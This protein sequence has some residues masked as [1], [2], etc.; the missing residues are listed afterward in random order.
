MPQND[1]HRT[2]IVPIEFEANEQ[3]LDLPLLDRVT[4]VLLSSG[5]ASLTLNG[6]SV[7]LE[8]PCMLLLSQNDQLKLEDSTRMAAKSFSFRPTFVN[9]SLT[10]ERLMADDFFELED[11]HDRNMM[12]L[13]LKRDAYYDGT[14]DLPPQTYLRIF[15]W[16]AIMG[17]ETYAQSD[18]YWTCRIRRYL[19][20][21]LYLLDDI[22]MNRKVPNTIKR[23]KSQVDILLEYIHTNYANEISLEL[24]TKVANLN[25]TSL[26]R[27]F[28]E[29]TGH[30]AMEYLLL[31]RLKIAC[32]AL[33]HTNLKLA[34]IA[35]AIGFRYDTYFIRQFSAR[36]GVTP[37]EYRQNARD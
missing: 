27:K 23:E 28:K 37:M 33:T 15:E 30:T 26:N 6:K 5:K 12:N 13:F 21:T 10:F 35:E 34:E 29:Q 24:L 3:F 8:A 36:M 7:V 9:S 11:E 31:Y 22:Y 32:D 25:R 17:T 20:Q 1:R 18:G 2:R 14:I 16:L 19:L 4:L